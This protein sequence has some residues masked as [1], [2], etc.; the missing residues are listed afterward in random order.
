MQK[1]TLTATFLLLS[2]LTLYGRERYLG[3]VLPGEDATAPAEEVPSGPAAPR[4][5][6]AARGAAA[7]DLLADLGQRMR[8]VYPYEATLRVTIPGL[9]SD[10]EWGGGDELFVVRAFAED[11]W[12]VVHHGDEHTFVD[13]SADGFGFGTGWDLRAWLAQGGPGGGGSALT[14]PDWMLQEEFLEGVDPEGERASFAFTLQSEPLCAAQ[15]EVDLETA[16]IASMTLSL[17]EYVEGYGVQYLD[18]QAEVTQVSFDVDAPVTGPRPGD[19]ARFAEVA[20]LRVGA[21]PGV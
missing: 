6:H 5:L 9:S 16:L 7:A 1:L 11:E 17:S 2:A 10:E 19:D 4:S 12:F 21:K 18:I 8:A 3:D 15:I 20:P 14:L 13:C